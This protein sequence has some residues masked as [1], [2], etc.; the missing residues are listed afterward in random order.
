MAVDWK[1]FDTRVW[2]TRA[3]AARARLKVAW[4]DRRERKIVIGLAILGLGSCTTGSAAAAWTRACTGTC[5]TAEQVQDFAPRQASQV[6]DA[7]GGLL[8]SFYRERRTVISIRSLPRYV[9]LAFTSIEDARFFQ[10]Q[11]VDPIRVLGAIRDNVIGGFGSTG[12]STITMQLARNLF[13]Q[14]LPPGEKSV[15]RKLAE[16]LN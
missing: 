11:G 10:H 15:R 8:G 14:Q 6:L 13:P 2:R 5:P 16:Y 3:E 4:A 9:P 7:R 12:G 1:R